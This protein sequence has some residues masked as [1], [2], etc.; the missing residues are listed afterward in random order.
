MRYDVTGQRVIQEVANIAFFDIADIFD[1]QGRLLPLDSIPAHARQAIASIEIEDMNVGFGE[2][3][4]KVGELKRV[5]FNS[6]EKA[7]EMLMKY[8][9][10]YEDKVKVTVE[11]NV[12]VKHTI[13]RVDLDERINQLMDDKLKDILG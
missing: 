5:K 11:G 9:R 1:S 7:L 13:D 12:D 10:L 2:N 6:K 3:K 8:L 4:M